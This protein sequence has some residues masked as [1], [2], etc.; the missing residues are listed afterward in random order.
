MTRQSGV[1]KWF[2]PTKGYGFLAPDAADARDVFV[3]E[4]EVVS[5]KPLIAGQ[6]VTYLIGTARDGRTI[7]RGVMPSGELQEGR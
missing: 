7:A 2:N 1:V 6:A 3:H 4:S 5:E